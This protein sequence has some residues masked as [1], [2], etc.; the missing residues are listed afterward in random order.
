MVCT[1]AGRN[2]KRVHVVI[3]LA[4]TERTD[5]FNNEA[6]DDT[7]DPKHSEHGTSNLSPIDDRKLEYRHDDSCPDEIA[8][9][10]RDRFILALSLPD[11][12]WRAYIIALLMSEL[13]SKSE[14]GRISAA[15][16]LRPQKADQ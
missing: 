2:C 16:R 10:V 7:G 12:R 3:S 14:T 11:A 8:R 9:Q 4:K 15:C 5:F 13:G 6:A 1:D